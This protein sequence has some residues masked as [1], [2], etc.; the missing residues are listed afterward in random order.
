MEIRTEEFILADSLFNQRMMVEEKMG[1]T[2]FSVGDCWM[3]FCHDRLVS[4]QN[5]LTGH[6]WFWDAKFTWPNNNGTQQ[7]LITKKHVDI[8]V[9]DAGLE[10]ANIKFVDYVELVGH[11]LRLIAEDISSRIIKQMTPEGMPKD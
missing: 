11:A 9:E 7:H 1:M 4:V 5:R 6:G 10:A 2:Q 3:T 8:S